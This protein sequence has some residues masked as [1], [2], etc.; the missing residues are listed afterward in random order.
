LI[1][2]VAMSL[3]KPRV[4][5]PARL[6]ANR[7]NAQKSTGPRTARGKAQSRLNGLQ[8]GFC[9]PLYREFWLSLFEAPPGTPVAKTVCNLLTPEE[10]LHPVYAELIDVHYEMELVDQDFS[11]RVRR[12][13]ARQALRDLKRSLEHIENN[14][15]TQSQNPAKLTTY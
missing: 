15:T 8:H 12:Q 6:A 1:E 2:G 10:S 14:G 13:R 9:S 7:R 4:M 3:L 11:R 5:T